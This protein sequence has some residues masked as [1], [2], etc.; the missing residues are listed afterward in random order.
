MEFSEGPPIPRADARGYF[1]EPCIFQPAP[2]LKTKFQLDQSRIKVY[3]CRSL[4]PSPACHRWR[5]LVRS[6]VMPPAHPARFRPRR[7]PLPSWYDD[8]KLGVF[9]HWSVSSVIGWAPT[10]LEINEILRQRYDDA[11]VHMPYTEWYENSIRL[12]ESPAAEHHRQTYGTR[13]YASFAADFEA[14]LAAWDPGS[15]AQT[16]RQAGARYVVLV[17]KHHDGYC[18]WPSAVANRRRPGWGSRRDLVSELADAVRAAGMR[19]GVYYSGGLDWTFEPMVLRTLGDVIASVPR[20]DYPAYA[21]AQVRELIA[22]VRPDVLWNDIAWPST[23]APL[24]RLFRDYYAAVPEGVV[25]DRW[26]PWTPLVGALRY[27]AVRRAFDA[28]LRRHFRNPDAGLLPSGIGH[29]D[30]QTTEYAAFPTIRSRKWECV[31][32]M[33]RSF[34]FNRSSR[35][36]HFLSQ[37][38]LIHSLVD[39]VAKNGNLLLNVGPRGEDATIPSEQMLRLQWL[40]EW[41]AHNGPAIYGTRPWVE[42]APTTIEGLPVRFTTREDRLFAIVLAEPTG[43]HVTLGGMRATAAATAELLG[44]GPVAL[45]ALADAVRIRLPDQRRASPAFTIAL[46]GVVAAPATVR[47]GADIRSPDSGSSPR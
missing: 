4:H 5:G 30:F 23:A 39:V 25:N 37:A 6:T 38:D 26:L 32:G 12:P 45:E 2:S 1:G 46:R 14:A 35:P 28:L 40:G 31:R 22:R 7:H 36:E 33:D 19:F 18:L 16:F 8:A 24:H 13:P 43:T 17:S 10:D 11:L 21:E 9:I 15:W 47:T 34:G 20:G 44:H 42:A 41:L 27:R 29:F 3:K